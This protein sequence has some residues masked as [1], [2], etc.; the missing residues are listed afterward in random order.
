V[1]QGLLEAA[2]AHGVIRSGTFVQVVLGP[3]AGTVADD[4]ED[5]LR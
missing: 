4:L 3:D 5:L 2:G 1:D